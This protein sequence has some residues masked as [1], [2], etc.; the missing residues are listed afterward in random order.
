ME[1]YREYLQYSLWVSDVK[2]RYLKNEKGKETYDPECITGIWL[3]SGSHGKYPVGVKKC[4]FEE[5]IDLIRTGH[6]VKRIRRLDGTTYDTRFLFIDLDN[7]IDENV[8]EEELK[9]L[10]KEIPGIRFLPSTSGNPHRWHIYLQ[11]EEYIRDNAGLESEVERI[12]DALR[13]ICCREVTCDSSCYRNWYQVCYGMPQ[14]G[15]FRLDIPEGTE[16]FCQQILKPND[17][18]SI[19]DIVKFLT[20]EE[21]TTSKEK[22][23][24]REFKF[25][26]SRIVPYNSKMLSRALGNPVLVDKAFSISP[27]SART[28][29]VA[30]LLPCSAVVV[31]AAATGDLFQRLAVQ[32]EVGQLGKIGLGLRLGHLVAPLL[33]QLH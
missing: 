1:E 24:D 23:S 3:D 21:F 7:D 29:I 30:V 4:T 11:T 10:E 20:Y 6:T 26:R 28:I 32:L 8:S 5:Y 25:S 22:T 14:E 33:C 9:K 27:A 13:E 31:P 15:G 18:E 12:M 2:K 17:R 16:F 19:E